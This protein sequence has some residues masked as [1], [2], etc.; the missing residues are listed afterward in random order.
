MRAI[1]RS[2]LPRC[3]A[4]PISADIL[5][6]HLA[7]FG[8]SGALMRFY[9][10]RMVPPPYSSR[11]AAPCCAVRTTRT[12]TGA[13]L[14]M[15]GVRYVNAGGAAP[16]GLQSSVRAAQS[17]A[18]ESRRS[19]VPGRCPPDAG[20]RARA[21]RGDG[22]LLMR[23]ED[24]PG[25]WDNFYSE[26]CTKLARGAAEVW[27]VRRE[28][29]L[30]ST[31]G[32]LRPFAGC[33]ISGRRGNLGSAARAGHRRLADGPACSGSGS[34][35]AACGTLLQNR[36]A[37]FLPPSWLCGGGYR[38]ALCAGAGCRRKNK[39]ALRSR[40]EKAGRRAADTTTK[41]DRE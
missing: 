18:G 21:R 15:Q 9:R 19:A 25:A 12:E 31:G 20:P 2:F 1:V 5:P 41:E 30:V 23:G 7:V 26:L 29:A 24:D 38:A 10:G 35:G 13:F 37:E 14:R 33:R 28:G 34:P 36:T 32:R 8:R 27:A 11:A 6:V 4:G 22:F 3:G 39:A 40:E 16:A 17:G